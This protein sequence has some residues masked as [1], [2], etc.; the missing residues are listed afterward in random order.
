[1][2]LTIGIGAVEAIPDAVIKL[3]IFTITKYISTY[4]KK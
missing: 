4:Y 3:L 1:M 2:G